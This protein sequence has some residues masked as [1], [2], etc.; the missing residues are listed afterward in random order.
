[1][2]ETG[3]RCTR[4]GRPICPDCMRPAAVGFHC[5]DDVKI[6]ARNMRA[7]RTVVG[8]PARV[9]ATTYVTWVLVAVNVI[10]YVIS[11]IG[12]HGGINSP[13]SSR[14]FKDWT[15]VPYLVANGADS[16]SHEF[17]RLITS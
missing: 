11:V 15:M 8:A 17:S 10:V 3:V 16:H 12:S 2:R 13:Q 14:L 7:P 9:W 5:P 6:A 4:C 1:M